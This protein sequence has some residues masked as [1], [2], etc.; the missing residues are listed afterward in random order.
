LIRDA[1][2]GSPVDTV[3][4]RE[5][6]ISP[7]LARNYVQST[8]LAWHG[9]QQNMT[10]EEKLILWGTKPEGLPDWFSERFPS[11][12]SGR[13]LFRDAGKD[14]GLV[15]LPHSPGGPL[16]S[17]PERAL[18]EMLSEVGVHQTIEEARSI[19]ESLRQL[20]SRQL[21]SLLDHCSQ[22][23]TI[24]LCVHWAEELQLPWAEKVAESQ[25]QKTGKSRWVKKLPNGRTLILK[26]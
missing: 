8:A 12:Y 16:L 26:P 18:L 23:K 3:F 6:E 24:R 17:S 21:I 1:P 19:L 7:S 11:R 10:T 13:R 5:K 9:Y 2:Y 20:R 14:L 25:K 15:T 22:I 4:L